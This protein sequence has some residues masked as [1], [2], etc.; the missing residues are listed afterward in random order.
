MEEDI[1]RALGQEVRGPIE[2]DQ[3]DTV[4]WNHKGSDATVEFTTDELTAF[5]PITNQ[6]DVYPTFRSPLETFHE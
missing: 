2:A 6:P 4:P 1:S 5:C 3:T